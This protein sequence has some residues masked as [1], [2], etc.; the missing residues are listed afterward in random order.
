MDEDCYFDHF[1]WRVERVAGC[2]GQ[3][4]HRHGFL[5]QRVRGGVTPSLLPSAI[6]RFDRR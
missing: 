3:A 6:D 1:L 4:A 5:W 2:A